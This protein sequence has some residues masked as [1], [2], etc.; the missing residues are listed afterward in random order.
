MV[1]GDEFIVSTI[2][3]LGDFNVHQQ[4][5]LSSPF[6]DYSGE[7]A[8]NFAILIDLEQLVQHPTR[9]LDRLRDTPNI[10][11]IF[12]TS[13][14][15]AYAATLYSP[16]GSSDHNFISVSCPISPILPQDSPKRRCLWHFA[17]AS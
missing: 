6:T 9:I 3:I 17:S 15:S 12:L 10:H 1:A 13:N 8:F 7:L 5:W 16:L 2:S 4:L 11:D 14:P